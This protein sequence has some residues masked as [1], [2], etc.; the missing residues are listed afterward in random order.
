MKTTKH[1]KEEWEE[2][3]DGDGV[4]YESE[5]DDEWS[6]QKDEV[7][8]GRSGVGQHRKKKESGSSNGRRKGK[9]TG[10]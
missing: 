10:T 1:E 2:E 4:D 5:G 7:P 6:E 3:E 8:K 9:R